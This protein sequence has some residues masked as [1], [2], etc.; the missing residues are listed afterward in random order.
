MVINLRK[1]ESDDWPLFAK[2]WRDEELIDLTSG[3]HS[4]LM[5]EEIKR[6]VD[7]MAED[8]KSHHWLIKADGEAIGHINLNQKDD[9]SVEMQIV[10]GEKNYWGKGI[11]TEAISLVVSEAKK[12]GYKKINA[13]VRPE[14]KRAL[15]L[16]EKMGFKKIGTKKYDNPNLPEVILF[17]KEL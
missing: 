8:I 10:I 14:N 12:L 1:L 2:W 5:D 4:P 3:D 13:E 15:R 9:N 11:G 16:Y 17:K 6:Q 7:D